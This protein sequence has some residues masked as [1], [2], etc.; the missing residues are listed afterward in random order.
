MARQ[1]LNKEP[2]LDHETV[3]PTRHRGGRSHQRKQKQACHR[4]GCD[5]LLKPRSRYGTCSMLCDQVSRALGDAQRV[6]AATDGPA[7]TEHWPLQR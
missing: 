5:Q 2:L 1:P 7:G 6:A 3:P 4:E